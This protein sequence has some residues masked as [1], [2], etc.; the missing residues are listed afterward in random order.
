MNIIIPLIDKYEIDKEILFHFIDNLNLKENKCKIFIIYNKIFDNKYPNINLIKLDNSIKNITESV[1]F[2]LLEIIN[3][4]K[5]YN[6]T[7]LISYNKMYNNDIIT[8]FIEFNK[9][10]V[11]YTNNNVSYCSYFDLD[12]N[13]DIDQNIIAYGFNNINN[14]YYYLKLKVENNMDVILFNHI[15]IDI[16][17]Y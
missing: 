9:N 5:F 13:N 7:L 1:Y 12:K 10:C 15:N 3:N 8:Q 4:Y 6:K 16:D 2:G 14:L 11:F 17:L